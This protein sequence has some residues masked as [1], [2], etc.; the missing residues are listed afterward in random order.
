MAEENQDGQEKTEQPT[1]KRFQDAKEKGQVPRSRELNTA[2]IMIMAA[3]GMTVFGSYMG[4]GLVGVMESAFQPQ[5]EQIFDSAAVF[6][7]L[8]GYIGRGL[9][10]LLPFALLM[11]LVALATPALMGGWAFSGKALLPKLEKLDPIKGLGRMFGPKALVELGKALAKVLVVGG[12][13]VLLM[14]SF[15]DDF[16]SLTS[17]GL[18][19]GIALGAKLFF[20][21]FFALSS[22]LLLV[23]AVDVPYQLYEHNKKLKMTKQEV[24]DEFK[25][26]EGK[27]EVKG[28][29]RQLQQQIAQGRMMERVP[30]AD[31][32]VTN[33]THYSVALKYDQLKMGAPK[34]LA[35]GAG[36]I[37]LRIR[38]RAKEHRIPVFEAPPLARALY[39]TTELEQ[40]VPN[41]L[42]LAV[43]QVLAYVYQ[44]KRPVEPGARPVRPNPELPE[45]FE[46]YANMGEEL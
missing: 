34:V 40:E 2:M 28:R 43:A 24:K 46:Q 20:F 37:A 22:A 42:Y 5:R 10:I 9:L 11:L 32:I 1:P 35:K 27:P 36:E 23:A 19:A 12:V 44:L 39:F 15:Q 30:E 16:R 29:I 25:Q 4:Y 31:V 8:R 14:W 38:E 18:T 3:F 21:A 7:L 6:D 13:G 41:G 45:E 33:P 26:T 17:I